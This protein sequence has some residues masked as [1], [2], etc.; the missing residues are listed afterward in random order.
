[1]RPWSNRSGDGKAVCGRLTSKGF[2]TGWRWSVAPTPCT[3][4]EVPV[5]VRP[6]ALWA[7]GNHR[8]L[9]CSGVARPTRPAARCRRSSARPERREASQVRRDERGAGVGSGDSPAETG[10]H[11]VHRPQNGGPGGRGFKSH[12]WLSRVRGPINYDD[13]LPSRRSRCESGRAHYDGRRVSGVS[14][15]SDR[16]GGR[17]VRTRTLR[18]EW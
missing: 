6:G 7:A 12:R 14:L 4:P 18:L 3:G 5:R 13:G 8:S 1:M 2:R 15:R 17:G 16:Q 11:R 10:C 9:R